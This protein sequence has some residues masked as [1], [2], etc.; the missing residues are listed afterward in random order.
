MEPVEGGG[1]FR[2]KQIPIVN[3]ALVAMEPYSG[4]VLAMVFEKSSTTC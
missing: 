4:R 1:A 3:G 2:L